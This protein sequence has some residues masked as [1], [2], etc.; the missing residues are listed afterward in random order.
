MAAGSCGHEGEPC[1]PGTGKHMHFTVSGS[2][3]TIMPLVA[4]LASIIS[5]VVSKR[6]NEHQ[7]WE[8]RFQWAIDKAVEEDDERSFRLAAK[9]LEILD[10]TARTKGQRNAVREAREVFGIKG[11]SDRRHG[12]HQGPRHAAKKRRYIVIG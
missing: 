5:A 10:S 6:V 12:R 4:L 3:L 7:R 2:G 8:N 1:A 9:M 11:S